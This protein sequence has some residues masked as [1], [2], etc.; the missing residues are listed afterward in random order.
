MSDL[1]LR[2]F[3]FLAVVGGTFVY[4]SYANATY[5]NVF[6]V[7]GET[8]IPTDIVTYASLV[9]M[10][11]DTNR[12]GVFT[13]PG[14]VGH[15][16][17]GSGSDGTT[18]WNVFNVEGETAIP[19]DI[20]TYA[21]LM[22]MLGDTNRTG[23]FTL[24]GIVGHNVVGSGS[25]GT[26]YWNVFNVES[27]TAIP[28]DIV[29]YA[30]LTDMLGDTNRTGVFTLPSIVGHNVV[31]SGAFLVQNGGGAGNNVPEPASIVLLG[32]GLAGLRFSRRK[33]TS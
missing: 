19:T 17:V 33:F 22:D 5:W 2:L 28:T 16:V 18:F 12:T 29:T 31:G 24:P 27:E 15:N 9:D 1:K 4:S 30:N 7:E 26:T 13:L 14:I 23:V 8:A 11:G 10:L 20:V 3:A 6:N 21:S 25:D 32:L